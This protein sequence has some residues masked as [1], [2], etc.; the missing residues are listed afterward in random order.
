MFFDEDLVLEVRLNALNKFVDYFVIVESRFNHKGEARDLKFNIKKYEKFNDKI[1]YLIH[2][3]L[4]KNIEEI[5]IKDSER[6]VNLKY[7][8]NAIKRENSQRNFIRE[9]LKD[10][11]DED[12]ILISDVD[13]IPNLKSFNL[14]DKISKIIVFEQYF[15]Y[16]KFDLCIP[17]FKWYGTKGCKKKNLLSPQ[18]LRNIKCRKYPKYRIDILFNK[19]KYNNIQFIKNGGWHFSNIKSPREIELKLKSYLHHREFEVDPMSLEEIEKT[20]NNKKAIYDLTVDKKEH[21]SGT[22][23]YLENFNISLLPDYIIQNK[24]KFLN[25]IDQKN[26]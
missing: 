26:I 13:E 6:T 2:E 18:W 3:D 16:Y 15:F 4:P 12:I 7:V 8:Y 19:K 23:V 14:N 25:W 20:I 11:N 9:A 21:K 1:I 24:D 10:A 22:G 17:N 5:K